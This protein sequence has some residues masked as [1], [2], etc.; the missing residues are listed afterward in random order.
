MNLWVIRSGQE[1]HLTVRQ[2]H[3]RCEIAEKELPSTPRIEAFSLVSSILLAVDRRWSPGRYPGSAQAHRVSPTA[4]NLLS[5]APVDN[6]LFT[7]PQAAYGFR[8]DLSRRHA[9][10]RVSAYH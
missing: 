1:N 5:T 3:P 10:V 8:V 2:T 6:G 7:P 4:Q 9:S